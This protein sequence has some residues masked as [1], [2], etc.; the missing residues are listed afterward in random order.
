MFIVSLFV[1]VVVA[2]YGVEGGYYGMGVTRWCMGVVVM[3][4]VMQESGFR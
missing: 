1:F 3:V 4:R 2:V